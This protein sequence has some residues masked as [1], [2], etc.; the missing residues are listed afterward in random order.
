MYWTLKLTEY[1]ISIDFE[2]E[3]TV[4]AF[5]FVSPSIKEFSNEK[6]NV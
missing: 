5:W 2:I 1:L 6:K 3:F 4:Y